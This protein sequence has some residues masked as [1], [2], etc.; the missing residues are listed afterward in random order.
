MPRIRSLAFSQ[1]RAQSYIQTAGLS[2]KL[3]A[4]WEMPPIRLKI[5]AAVGTISTMKI[6]ARLVAMSDNGMG[7]FWDL[8]ITGATPGTPGMDNV[9][10]VPTTPGQTSLLPGESYYCPDR[11]EKDTHYQ[12]LFLA[13]PSYDLGTIYDIVGA[14][15]ATLRNDA[16][17]T[18]A[19][20]SSDAFSIGGSYNRSFETS[21]TNA[22]NY[23]ATIREPHGTAGKLGI[24]LK[25]RYFGVM[26]TCIPPEGRYQIVY[27][28]LG[29]YVCQL[30]PDA[31]GRYWSGEYATL[32]TEQAPGPFPG[33]ASIQYLRT[34]RETF[35]FQAGVRGRT[36]SYLL[37]YDGTTG[38]AK[39]FS[40]IFYLD[41]FSPFTNSDISALQLPAFSIVYT[42]HLSRLASFVT[43]GDGGIGIDSPEQPTGVRAGGPWCYMEI[44]KVKTLQSRTGILADSP[45]AS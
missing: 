29:N 36:R 33:M 35:V 8:G 11:L 23:V 4:T 34:E 19:V 25:V 22:A 9:N 30:L 21:S 12:N 45:M 10:L 20:N 16:N 44:T 17:A 3:A 1:E 13:T 32:P 39:A 37:N 38:G 43:G 41:L 15:R 42:P 31:S 18:W 2:A 24:R 6:A 7:Y 28:R 5:G 26:P 14:M 27:D 40:Y